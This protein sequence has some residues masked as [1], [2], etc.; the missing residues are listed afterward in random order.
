MKIYQVDSFTN[1]PF[2]GNPAGVCYTPK[3]LHDQ[4]MQ[5]IASEMSLPETAFCSPIDEGLS[6]RWFTPTQEIELCGHATLACAHVLFS[7]YDFS[8]NQTLI[9]KTMS[10]ELRVNKKQDLYEMDFPAIELIDL[11]LEGEIEFLLGAEVLEYKIGQKYAVALLK[12][13]D[14]IRD[15][16]PDLTR[17]ASLNGIEAMIVTAKGDA[18]D[19]VSRF[20]GPALGIPE[21][22]VTGAAHCRLAPYWSQKLGKKLMYAKQLSSRGGELEVEVSDSDRVFLR[23]KAVTTLEA[24]LILSSL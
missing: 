13:E 18:V 15:L 6:L 17:L 2:S 5:N 16:T 12:D 20:F 22:P 14:T 8:P 19:F 4:L 1:K 23:G 9:F 24:K 11:P 7:H 21:D 3:P 10:G